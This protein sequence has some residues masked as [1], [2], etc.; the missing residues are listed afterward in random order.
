MLNC[1]EFAF[2]C[3][4]HILGYNFDSRYN[5]IYTYF[6]PIAPIRGC[7]FFLNH[8]TP[9]FFTLDIS[10]LYLQIL[11]RQY[12]QK[13]WREFCAN[14][15]QMN[16]ME[17]NE[18]SP[19]NLE[20]TNRRMTIAHLNNDCLEKVF[21]YL[22]L[23]DLTNVAES[24]VHLAISTHIVFTHKFKSKEFKFNCYDKHSLS[25][26]IF[27][28]VL[29]H[30]GKCISKLCVQ[31]C[32]DDRRS[33]N[34]FDG[35]VENCRA[36]LIEM[37]LLGVSKAI[38]LTMPFLAL[39]K[40]QLWDSLF[41]IDR[42]LTCINQW[43]PNLSCAKFYNIKKFWESNAIVEHFP[44]LESFGFLTFPSQEHTEATLTKLTS[45]LRLNPQLK[46]IEL[47]ELDQ[48]G[49][50]NLTFNKLAPNLLPNIKR[51]EVV[52]PF[53]FP[54]LFVFDNLRELSLSMYRD[55]SDTFKQ[56]PRTIE[57]FELRMSDISTSA[58]N[59]ILSC[60]N[61]KE[62]KIITRSLLN[63]VDL[64]EISK[65]LKSLT[66]VHINQPR[67]LVDLTLNGLEHFFR[68]SEN[69]NAISLDIELNSFEKDNLDHKN[70][71]EL[72]EKFMKLINIATNTKWRLSHETHMNQ[73]DH[74][75]HELLSFPFLLISFKKR[76]T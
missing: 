8:P 61:L 10:R 13:N 63:T 46:C 60:T 71:V 26:E 68:N 43:F 15:V 54:F 32:T 59:Y 11:S 1:V 42:S 67:K 70:Q 23:T 24:N 6:F 58:I 72:A 39:K 69:M 76:C 5:S 45:F 53:P 37:K 17:T 74:R 35:I 2:L 7:F 48:F 62:L 64:R 73:N 34:I 29:Q 52:S 4:R 75:S 55:T 41:G 51:L 38:K 21:S 28:L 56:L 30:F 57:C 44:K 50:E 18:L 9:T 47:D 49:N 65:E 3:K 36:T 20:P 40:L 22:C 14:Y 31:L 33:R 66:K 25:D 12:L 19:E 16:T 27:L